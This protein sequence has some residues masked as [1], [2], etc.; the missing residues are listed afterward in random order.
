MNV[1]KHYFLFVIVLF[2]LIPLVSSTEEGLILHYDFTADALDDSSNSNNGELGAAAHIVNGAVTLDGTANSFIAAQNI[3][4]FASNAITISFW[5]NN[6][7]AIPASSDAGGTEGATLLSYVVDGA[8]EQNANKIKIFITRTP[9]QKLRMEMS[10][11]D[12][13]IVPPWTIYDNNWHHFVI[14]WSSRTGRAALYVD[15]ISKNRE[16]RGEN[17]I[18]IAT[19]KSLS[20][21]GTLVVGQSQVC[22]YPALCAPLAGQPQVQGGFNTATAFRGQV[23]NIRIYNIELGGIR[24]SDLSRARGPGV[25]EICDNAVD[26]DVDGFI[27]CRD[28]GDCAIPACTQDLQGDRDNDLLA[29]SEDNCP[30]FAAP[31]QVDWDNDGIG[32]ACD[33][34]EQAANPNQEDSDADAIG[35][36]CDNCLSTANA[37]QA[38]ADGDGIGNACVGEDLDEDSIADGSDNCPSLPNRNQQNSDVDGYGDACDNCPLVTEYPLSDADGDGAG[39]A[40]DPDDDNDNLVDANDNCPLVANPD[41]IDSERDGAGDACDPNDDNDGYEDNLD[42]CPTVFNTAHYGEDP[43]VVDNQWDVDRD[44]RGDACDPDDDNDAVLDAQD[45]CPRAGN[46]DQQDTD[47]NGVGD[48]CERDDDNDGIDD[49]YDNCPLVPNPGQENLDSGS[50]GDNKQGDVCDDDDDNDRVPDARDNCPYT[51]IIYGATVAFFDQTDSDNDGLGDP[52]DNDDDNDIVPDWLDNCRTIPNPDQSNTDWWLDRFGD[53]CDPDDDNDWVCDTP[54]NLCTFGLLSNGVP[55]MDNCPRSPY[56]PNPDQRDTNGD[57]KGD[58]C[59]DDDDGDGVTDHDNCPLVAN[60]NQNDNDRDNSGDACDNDDDNDDIP[61]RDDYCPLLRSE[62]NPLDSDGDGIP[63]TCDNCDNVAN[64]DQL[65]FDDGDEGDACDNE[66]DNDGIM[67]INDTCPH[68]PIVVGRGEAMDYV[69][70]LDPH[71][72]SIGCFVFDQNQDD[73][74]DLTDLFNVGKN[75]GSYSQ[76]LQT[77]AESTDLWCR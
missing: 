23:D 49:D 12:L 14:T 57:G 36:A 48:A 76:F 6:L 66:W 68:T 71:D 35:N 18:N 65:N 38:D 43:N 19:G 13:I 3:N 72:Q 37:D 62:R 69:A 77:I 24:I 1:G 11:S 17:R 61:D 50:E 64:V 60:P 33:N 59:Q 21:G 22:E 67:N 28:W 51:R 74:I 31:A 8:P 27:D 52:C 4:N 40:C 10:G 30:D 29:N 2:L 32:N 5:A 53:V 7:G 70:G 45:N 47:R 75:M 56:Q 55:V 34:C 73:C 25:P 63:D 9:S 15:G 16:A 39:D 20:S 41:Q 54:V 46:A 58:V 26:D 42:N 44:G